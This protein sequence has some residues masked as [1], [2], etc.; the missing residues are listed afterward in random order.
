M[1][2]SYLLIASL[3][4]SVAAMAQS[5]VRF[6][7]RGG[8]SSASLQGDAVN[9]LQN[10][11]Q[12]SKGAVST[13]SRTGFYGG[14]YA[15]IPVSEKFSIEPGL[16]YSQKGY[17]VQGDL[18]IK[19]LDLLGVNAKAQLNTSY[20]DLPILAKV[21]LNGFEIF[22]GPQVSYLANASLR[23]TAG[24]LGFNVLDSKMDATNQFNKW[25]A[26]ITG[27]IG[28]EFSNGFNLRASYDYGLMKVD[29][30]TSF[31]AYNRAV[32]VGIGFSF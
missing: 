2:K 11:L 26:A 32:K 14:G 23:T 7:I 1:K 21:N 27:G 24:A 29:N 9:S 22:A 15:N 28:Y 31:N 5:D 10:L 6:G 18:N 3:I 16:Y 8:V 13:S 12:F 19:V 30:G 25:D 4:L 20:I 17:V